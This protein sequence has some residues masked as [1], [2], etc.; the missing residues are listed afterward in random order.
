MTGGSKG[1]GAACCRLLAREGWAVAINHREG[2]KEAAEMVK[3]EIVA[4]GGAAMTFQADVT[5]ETEVIGMFEAVSEWGQ[6]AGLV[7]NAGRLMGPNKSKT[8]AE[9]SEED[10]SAIM[11]AN[12]V[13][14]M[15]CCRRGRNT[16][17]RC[18]FPPPPRSARDVC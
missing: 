6:L 7:N 4:E 8:V 13:G 15:L 12:V 17:E 16:R 18:R 1:I 5:V 2:S 10:L 14:P 11:A 3:A 9:A